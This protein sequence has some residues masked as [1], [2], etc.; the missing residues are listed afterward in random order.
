MEKIQYLK[1]DFNLITD[2]NINASEFRVL[3]YLQTKYN[4]DSNIA[5]PSYETIAESTNMGI[6]TA[7]RVIK[8]LA[9]LNYLVI[10]KKKGI[11]GNYNTYS[12]L[13][14]LILNKTKENVKPYSDGGIAKSGDFEVI[15]ENWQS[16]L[17][18]N[19]MD[20]K[21]SNEEVLEASKLDL[22][23]LENAIKITNDKNI[24]N[25]KYLMKVYNSNNTKA[26]VTSYTK[27]I[28]NKVNSKVSK[29]SNYT[30]RT[31]DETDYDGLIGWDI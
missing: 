10:G 2:N 18:Q 13:K 22:N 5:Y 8:H 31:Y 24:N 30:Q 9:K 29:F 6:A 23:K 19:T 26:K 14:N 20:I 12:K 15:D 27:K 16:Q 3:T 28:I 17:I 21:L 4:K 25:F 11:K 7:K 1:V